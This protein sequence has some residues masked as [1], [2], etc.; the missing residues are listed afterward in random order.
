MGADETVQHARRIEAAS[1]SIA[2]SIE[3]SEII[4]DGRRRAQILRMPIEDAP[5]G[6]GR[7]PEDEGDHLWVGGL[8]DRH[9]AVLTAAP[10][11]AVTPACRLGDVV[12]PRHR[13]PHAAKI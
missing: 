9:D 6:I 10:V 2:S 4:L 13:A 3:A 8:E 5:R 12:E 1:G 11:L 7:W